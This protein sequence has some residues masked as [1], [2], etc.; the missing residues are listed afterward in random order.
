M[1]PI[2]FERGLHKTKRR[3]ITPRR[4]AAAK[5]ALRKQRDKCPLFADQVAAIQPTPEQRIWDMDTQFVFHWDKLRLATCKKWLKLRKIIREEICPELKNEFL[6][7]WS[8]MKYPADPYYASDFL[9]WLIRNRCSECPLR[10]PQPQ[11]R[12]WYFNHDTGG[13]E[14]V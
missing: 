6:V 5:R 4:L 12:C 1:I 10:L 9:L 7:S 3:G 8:K 13:K 11:F 2:R 14:N